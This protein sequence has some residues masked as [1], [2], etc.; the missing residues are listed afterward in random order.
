MISSKQEHLN[1]KIYENI[2][3]IEIYKLTSDKNKY[4]VINH[5]KGEILYFFIFFGL[6]L[7]DSVEKTNRK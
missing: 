4:I 2:Q 3:K 5:L 7:A 1:C 6:V